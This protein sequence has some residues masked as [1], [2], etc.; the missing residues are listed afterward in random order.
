MRKTARQVLITGAILSGFAIIGSALVAL[1]Y[2]GTEERIE[3]A[4]R[5][6]LLKRLHE[7]V[8]PEQSD[9]DLY[10]DVIEVTDKSLL[11]SDKPVQIYRARKEGKPVAALLTPIAPNGYGGAIKLLVAV[12]IDGTLAGVR[13]LQHHETPGLGDDI[14]TERSD[15]IL[16]FNNHSLNSLTP[17]QWQVKKDGGVFDQF[18]GATITPRAIVQAVH[19]SLNYFQQYQETLFTS[20]SLPREV[21]SHE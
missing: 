13:V 14:D 12:N 1:T 18:T 8:T 7:L 4:Q 10:H 15:W 2:Q 19:R 9:N 21:E 16:D 11:G 6:A 17:Q 3:Q 20:P 5:E